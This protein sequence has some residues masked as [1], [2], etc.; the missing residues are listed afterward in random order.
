MP[1]KIQKHAHGDYSVVNTESGRVHSK[2]TSKVKA[3]AQVRLLRGIE[4][5]MVVR[6]KDKK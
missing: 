4:Y 2:H 1:Y 5:G 6:K 3:E